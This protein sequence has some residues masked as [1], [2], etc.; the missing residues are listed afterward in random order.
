MDLMQGNRLNAAL[1][2]AL[3]TMTMLLILALPVWLT[4]QAQPIP[5]QNPPYSPVNVSFT[6]TTA[7]TLVAAPTAGAVCVYGLTLVNAGGSADTVSIYLDG[8][9]TAV[10]TV[11]LAASGGS[12]SWQLGSNPQNPYF[13]TNLTTGF[14]IK[15]G[16][17]VQINGGIYAATCP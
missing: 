16:T 11:Y 9:T 17:N 14:V 8:G 2:L 12:A 15:S 5:W 4:V 13:L 3:V 6:G 7:Q 1:W 10:T